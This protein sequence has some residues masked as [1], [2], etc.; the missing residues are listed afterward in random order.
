M[1][2]AD[3]E[4]PRLVRATEQD[5]AEV[6]ALMNAAYRGADG[7]WTTEAGHIGGSRTDAAMLRDDIARDPEAAL[8]VWRQPDGR[9]VGCVWLE[10]VGDGGCYLGSL[11]VE[12]RRQNAGLGRRLLAAAE[13][14]ARRHGARAVEMTVVQV[15]GELIDWYRRRGYGPTGGTKPFPYGDQRFGIPKRDDLHFIVLRKSLLAEPPS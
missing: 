2:A 5:L 4:M 10:P 6:V 12:P 7:G 8:L 13:D 3:F 1:A 11:T 15:R 9:L 14:W